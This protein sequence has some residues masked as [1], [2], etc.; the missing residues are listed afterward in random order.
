M[1][2]LAGAVSCSES[3][4]SKIESGKASPSLNMLHRMAHHL[5]T[6]MGQLFGEG[7]SVGDVVLRQGERPMIKSSDNEAG[8]SIER[9]ISPGSDRLLQGN[10]HHIDPD[11]ASEGEITHAGEEFG[12]VLAGIVEL[13]V[14]GQM[15]RLA[16]GDAFHF[17]SERPHAYRNIGA[18][19]ARILWIN[20]PPTY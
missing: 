19:S 13:F 20:T 12:Y 5:E 16:E 2:Q 10:L 1:A 3:F 7:D 17:G 9:M 11:A 18:A 8:I 14:A 4:V 15:F 6:N